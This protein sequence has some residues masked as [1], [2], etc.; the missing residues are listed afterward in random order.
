MFNLPF[1]YYIIVFGWSISFLLGYGYHYQNKYGIRKGRRK[2]ITFKELLKSV[3]EDDKS[4]FIQKQKDTME[5]IQQT[6]Q[7]ISTKMELVP[8]NLAKK[9]LAIDKP[10]EIE[11]IKEGAKLLKT[12]GSAMPISEE[13]RQQDMRELLQVIEKFE[14]MEQETPLVDVEENFRNMG[15]GLWMDAIAGEIRKV[16]ADPSIRKH[17]ILQVQKLAQFLPKQF[18]IKDIRN[19]LELLKKS[20][21]IEGIVELT[22]EISVISFTKDAI[23]LNIKEKIL[24]TTLT[25]E[26][27]LTK[28]KIKLLFNWPDNEIDEIILHLQTLNIIKIQDNEIIAKGMLNKGEKIREKLLEK[29]KLEEKKKKDKERKIASTQ[30]MP[31]VPP[32]PSKPSV[33]PVPSKPSV[34]PIPPKPSVPPVPSKPSV[35]PI[36]PKPSVPPVPSKPSVPPVP[37]KSISPLPVK[38]LP[39]GKNE[40]S[41]KK[42]RK[43]GFIQ[44]KAEPIDETQRELDIEDLMGAISYLEKEASFSSSKDDLG[45]YDETGVP[46]E[47]TELLEKNKPDGIKDDGSKNIVEDLSEKILEVYEKH[48]NIIGG[49]MQI[50]KLKSLLSNHVDNLDDKRFQATLNVL[51]SIG[52][53]KGIQ[54][55]GN[56]KKIIKFSDVSLGSSELKIL[57]KATE[58]SAK[59][60]NKEKL[61]ELLNLSE[62]Q[63]LS[64]L[65]SLQEKG[66]IRYKGEGTIEIPGL[67]QLDS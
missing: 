38:S 8:E 3:S 42:V 20:K 51:Q 59:S 28:Q 60:F 27:K 40:I 66:I 63:L 43:T 44:L 65:K 50:E 46:V 55:L 10:Q 18:D 13:Q 26:E 47:P 62:D 4:S 45:I 64:S 58:I 2:K 7:K 24:L 35:A 37:S 57:E 33:P 21:E 54:D 32:V 1:Y 14:E 56:G 19:A 15:Y 23:N 31:S 53:I 67:I 52:M 16:I 49:I 29:K 25:S 11:L 6:K 41:G 61:M 5:L 34:A 30:A 17:V 9:Y 36:P 22:P 39:L 48:E 12:Y